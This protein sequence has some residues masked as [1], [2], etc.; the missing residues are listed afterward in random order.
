M[1][2]IYNIS[3]WSNS[4]T[5]STHDIVKYNN[6]FYYS[7]T[8]NNLNNTPN[9]V[10]SHW[11]GTVVWNGIIK[12]K[13]I[14]APS[15][16]HS[17]NVEPRVKVMKYGEGYEQSVPDG[18]NNTL[19]MLELTFD[20]RNKT[21]ATAINHFLDRRKGSDSFV[22]TPTEPYNIEKLFKCR[23]WSSNYVF[24]DNFSIRTRFE[25]VSV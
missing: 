3:L 11:G 13:F 24:F 8:N 15:Y 6:Y 23:G 12:P 9:E 10:S 2:S 7:K 1:A 19:L 14:W 25:E 20:L 5:Y 18:I 17:I 16:N 4:T 22:F 21:E